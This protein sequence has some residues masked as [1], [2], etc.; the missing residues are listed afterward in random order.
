M[1]PVFFMSMIFRCQL[2]KFKAV[3]VDTV[4]NGVYL[5]SSTKGRYHKGSVYYQFIRTYCGIGL[6]LL[7]AVRMHS[8]FRW[9]RCECNCIGTDV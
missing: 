4:S 3:N 7:A 9:W 1:D 2:N 5:F 8:L 6:M